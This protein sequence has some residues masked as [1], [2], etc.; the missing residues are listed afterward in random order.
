M[1]NKI[2]LITGAT[3]G[4][5]E[6]TARLLSKN[7]FNLIICG[8]REDRLVRLQDELASVTK[9]HKL[10]FDVRDVAAVKMAL[11]ALPSEWKKIDVLINNA[12]N[13]HG[14]DPI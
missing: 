5:G 12:G 9:V 13:A 3:S 2:A 8:R 1:T 4:I 10:A 14:L 7:Q 11:Q 6:A